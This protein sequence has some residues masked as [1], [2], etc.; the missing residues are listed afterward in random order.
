MEI[1]DEVKQRM[2]LDRIGKKRSKPMSEETRIKIGNATRGKTNYFKGKKRSEES[3]I[4]MSQSKIGHF[5]SEETK[6]KIS[7]TKLN[8]LKKI[9]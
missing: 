3:K 6:L 2:S 4:K 7:R 9:A 5:V 8:R 1:S